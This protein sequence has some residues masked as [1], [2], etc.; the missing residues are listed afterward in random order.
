MQNSRIAGAVA[1]N[2]N[3]MS[4]CKIESITKDSKKA[5]VVIESIYTQE[6]FFA[7]SMDEK[8]GFYRNRCAGCVA[9]VPI[10]KTRGPVGEKKRRRRNHGRR[11]IRHARD[12]GH[13]ATALH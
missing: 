7:V 2:R 10:I 6:V 13:L 9:K 5:E 8:F 1:R 3:R 11:V 12:G 4:L